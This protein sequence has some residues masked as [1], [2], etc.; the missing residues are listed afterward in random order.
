MATANELLTRLEEGDAAAADE[1]FPIVY[2][3]LR[4]LARRRIRRERPGHTLQTTA[5]LNEAYLRLVGA[6]NKFTHRSHFFAAASEAMRRILVERARAKCRLK[7]GGDLARVELGEVAEHG[8]A[9]PEELLAVNDLFDR[10]AKLNP[11]EA[12]VAKLHYFAGFSIA[13]VARQLSIPKTTAYR[14]WEF[15]RAWLGREIQRGV[16]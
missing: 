9:P 15:A 13:E 2:E 10:F 1:L 8:V 12:A 14:H 5:L 16:G 11:E 3:E 7:R 4:R 6:N